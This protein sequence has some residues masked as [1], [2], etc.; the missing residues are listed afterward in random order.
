MINQITDDGPWR[1]T[2]A[3][4]AIRNL[5]A[6]IPKVLLWLRAA[7]KPMPRWINWTEPTRFCCPNG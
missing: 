1:V 5:S 3:N 7:F 4:L 2:F 6:K